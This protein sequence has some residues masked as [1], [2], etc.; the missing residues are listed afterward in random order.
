MRRQN[1]KIKV[2]EIDDVIGFLI[3]QLGL[4]KLCHIFSQLTLNVWRV[5]SLWQNYEL[6][7]ELVPPYTPDLDPSDYFQLPT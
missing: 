1:R 6:D 3:D 7:Y 4:R 5:Q 2:R